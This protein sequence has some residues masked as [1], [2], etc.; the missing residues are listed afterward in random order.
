M[1]PTLF[2]GDIAIIDVSVNSITEDDVYAFA[3]GDEAYIK[4]LQWAGGRLLVSSDN[5]AYK[6][7]EIDH[8]D[9]RQIR[10]FGRV[11]GSIRKT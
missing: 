6:T 8:A 2:G 4:R 1:E 5:Q 9:T 7:W 11:A 3:L 10:V